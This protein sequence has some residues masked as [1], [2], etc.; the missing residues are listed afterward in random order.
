MKRKYVF[1]KVRNEE[2]NRVEEDAVNVW[3][4]GHESDVRRWSNH[5]HY[6]SPHWAR[7]GIELI[8]KCDH[9]NNTRFI[10]FIALGYW[11][12]AILFETYHNIYLYL[13]YFRRQEFQSRYSKCFFQTALIVLQDAEYFSCLSNPIQRT[14]W[15]LEPF[16]VFLGVSFCSHVIRTC[17]C[18]HNSWFR[19]STASRWLWLCRFLYRGHFTQT[20]E[21]RSNQICMGSVF[22][23]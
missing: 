6:L 12:F 14:L 4:S 2:N 1:R 20:Y 22:Y 23:P 8:R 7:C 16:P 10:R 18:L 11:P 9:A 17:Q 13:E 21:W 19:I 3:A 5:T 15:F